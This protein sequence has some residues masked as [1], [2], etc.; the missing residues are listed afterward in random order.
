MTDEEIRI[1][2]E[3]E[4]A[5]N[6]EMLKQCPVCG[7]ET[8]RPECPICFVEHGGAPLTG[9]K[10]IDGVSAKL[11]DGEKITPEEMEQILRGGF[12]PIDPQSLPQD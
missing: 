2:Y 1:E 4:L 8:H 9:D 6:G 5:W 12:I 10:V 7:F 3:A 11:K